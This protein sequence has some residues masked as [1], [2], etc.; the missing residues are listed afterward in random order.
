MIISVVILGQDDQTSEEA[1]PVRDIKCVGSPPHQP[2]ASWCP[3]NSDKRKQMAGFSWT[4]HNFQVSRQ[5][6][7]IWRRN[8]PSVSSLFLYSGDIESQSFKYSLT[9]AQKRLDFGVF[10][11]ISGKLS[12]KILNSGWISA[13]L[14]MLLQPLDGAGDA[15]SWNYLLRQ[16]PNNSPLKKRVQCLFS[17]HGRRKR[18]DKRKGWEQEWK[19]DAK[20]FYEIPLL[21]LFIAFSQLQL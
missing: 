6:Q 12:W 16:S 21:K 5:L 14:Q 11:N 3:H 20:H 15:H 8:K 19:R 9:K 7:T 17:Q 13:A 10:A 1:R 2:T 18:K 4:S